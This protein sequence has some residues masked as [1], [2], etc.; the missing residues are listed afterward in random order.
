ML[1][2]FFSRWRLALLFYAYLF[3]PLL[4]FRHDADIFT[5]FFYCRHAMMIIYD[6]TPC[7]V[8]A[9]FRFAADITL[10]T[11]LRWLRAVTRHCLRHMRHAIL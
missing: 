9:F 10:T 5:P 1:L 8:A 6:D 11:C 3:S 7:H 2:F 4:V